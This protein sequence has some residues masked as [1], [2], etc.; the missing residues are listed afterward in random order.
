MISHIV[1]S[2][3]VARTVVTALVASAI[4]SSVSFAQVPTQDDAIPQI[5]VKYSDLNL[6]TEEGSRALYRR[7]VAAAEHVCPD[8]GYVTELRYNRDVQRCIADT[9]DRAVKGIDHPRFARVAAA[10]AHMR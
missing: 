9:V 1:S 8:R 4:G 5:S 2:V 3:R 6:A 7:L 10:Q